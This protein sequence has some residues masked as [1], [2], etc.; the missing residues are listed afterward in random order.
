VKC[1]N[2]SNPGIQEDAQKN[3]EK[4][5]ATRK[6]NR[7]KNS[8]KKNLATTNLL[9]FDE[10]SQKRIWEQVLQSNTKSDRGD[11]PSVVL[12]ITTTT[13]QSKTQDPQG[14]RSPGYIFVVDVQV[15]AAGNPLKQ[16]M[17]ISIQS[18]LPHI[19]LQLGI[20]LYC[21]DCPTI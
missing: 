18:N 7:E 1:P 20:D 10:T 21:P 2:K 3:L 6:R 11:I 14:K 4:Y 8:K 5:R 17:P 15:L 19:A 16:P 13:N 12:A 9:D